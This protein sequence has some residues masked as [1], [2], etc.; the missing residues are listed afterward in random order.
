M[1]IL[2]D[3][4][5]RSG[6]QGTVVLLDQEKAYDQVE[7][8]YLLQ[9]LNRFSFSS[10]WMNVITELYSQPGSSQVLVNGFKSIHFKICCGLWQG[11]PLS[12]ILYNLTLEPFLETVRQR[13]SSIVCWGVH[14]TMQSLAD[15]TAPFLWDLDDY[16][17]LEEVLTIYSHAS[18]SRLNDVKLVLITFAG[19]TQQW[20]DHFPCLELGQNHMILG[21]INQF[22][23]N[24]PRSA[25][26]SNPPSPGT[27]FA[28]LEWMGSFGKGPGPGLE[29]AFA[30]N[31]LVHGD[32]HTISENVHKLAR[33]T[34]VWLYLEVQEATPSENGW[35]DWS[36]KRWQPWTHLFHR[37]T[38]QSSNVV[39]EG[40]LEAWA[41]KMVGCP[42]MECVKRSHWM[43][44]SFAVISR[45]ALASNVSQW[46]SS[47]YYLSLLQNWNHVYTGINV[48]TI[49]H[50]LRMLYSPV[51]LGLVGPDG[52][53]INITLA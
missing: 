1:H 18:G 39:V 23:W 33:K 19:D 45:C 3:K 46:P 32:L 34:N 47:P 29:H 8:K 40:I 38:G 49:P 22:S 12:P 14:F 24:R 26:T 17:W 20:L 21:S 28:S 37:S 52:N 30:V 4:A 7:W 15:N 11:D 51:N 41:S 10:I 48:S 13:L 27:L 50:P 16:Q 2:L 42:G 31:G 36:A 25:R 44:H 9:C 6:L 35:H 53:P 5:A 43:R